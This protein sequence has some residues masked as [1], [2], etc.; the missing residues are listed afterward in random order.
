MPLV[1]CDFLLS[2]YEKATGPCAVKQEKKS[3]KELRREKKAEKKEKKKNES[4]NSR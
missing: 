4:A 3:K 1:V 2:D